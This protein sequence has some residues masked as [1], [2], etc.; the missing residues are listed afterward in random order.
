MEDHRAERATVERA[1][2]T[3]ERGRSVVTNEAPQCAV[4]A[5]SPRAA[6]PIEYNRR[7]TVRSFTTSIVGKL[8]TNRTSSLAEASAHLR[9]RQSSRASARAVAGRKA[10]LGHEWLSVISVVCASKRA[11]VHCHPLQGGLL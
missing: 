9:Y 7:R 2:L 11:V 8:S 5:D 6:A 4:P 3:S 1:E 10:Y